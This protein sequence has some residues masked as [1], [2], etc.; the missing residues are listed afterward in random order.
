MPTR[1]PAVRTLLLILSAWMCACLLPRAWSADAPAAVATAV[2]WP[3]VALSQD[4]TL[5]LYH[6]H[7]ESLTGNR[8]TA[9]AAFS[10]T[11]PGASEP[12][13]GVV[14]LAARA[15]ID[16]DTRAIHLSDE[17]AT[18]VRLPGLGAADETAITGHVTG[19]VKGLDLTLS[20][21][22]IL[23]A[24]GVA[25]RDNAAVAT[26]NASPP[27][28]IVT[29]HRALLLSIDGEPKVAPIPGSRFERIVNTPYLVARDPATG[30]CWLL[31]GGRWYSA[32]AIGGHWQAVA[33][34]SDELRTLAGML[35]G[36][37]GDPLATPIGEPLAIV[38]ATG[39]AELISTDGPPVY[40]P[41]TGTTLLAVT[42]T[43]NDLFQDTTTQQHYVLLNGRW[44][45]TGALGAGTWQAV[46]AGSL[47]QDF[48]RIP[49]QSDYGTI[50][51]HV[52]GTPAAE[53][54]ALDA[55]IPQTAAVARTATISVTYDGDPQWQPIANTQLSYAVNSPMAV[56]KVAADDYYCCYQGVWYRA[57][58]PVGP[59]TVATRRPPG[60]S[61]IP[62]ENPLYN[63]QYVYVYDSTPDYVYVG[64][65]PGYLGC[66]VVD[67]CVVWGTGFWYPGWWGTWYYPGF[68]TWGFG[69]IYNP[70]TGHWGVGPHHG[71]GG[72]NG[73]FD[74]IR[75]GWWGPG[76]FRPALILRQPTDSHGNPRPATSPEAHGIAG[77]AYSNVYRSSENQG[78]ILPNSIGREPVH[79]LVPPR[80]GVDAGAREEDHL[81]PGRDGDVFRRSGDG[82]QQWQREGWTP[83][84]A[85][86][87]AVERAAPPARS[88]PAEPVAPPSRV[89]QLYQQQH[90]EER[91]NQRYEQ[92][93]QY[94]SSPPSS[95]RPSSTGGGGR[96][97][98]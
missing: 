79:T 95:I 80:P 76:G 69:M 45:R 23:A 88:T 98:H 40:E 96:S 41:I 29:D 28:I 89:Q 9:R 61:S 86:R 64:Y 24:L 57:P 54:A 7:V 47:P 81:Q 35:D 71:L 22:R 65:T 42:N 63:V 39:P 1:P 55:S 84:P 46:P 8:I 93:Q 32:P 73:G 14:W 15:D 75:G 59:W 30:A 2:E 70:W 11:A 43:D 6:P 38:V 12:T 62:P 50:L 92:Y 68:R 13:F 52:A 90:Y 77:S 31:Y 19:L 27:T 74:H 53:E 58:S 72:R 78:R 87:P 85:E 25:E 20:L 10:L 18:R 17:Q 26:L 4:G 33:T 48:S 97:R 66:Y 56:I 82:W 16:R 51:A 34:V 83:L 60:I 94:R 44:F 49:P 3:L 21:D 91:G 37:G 67:G 36:S 5:R